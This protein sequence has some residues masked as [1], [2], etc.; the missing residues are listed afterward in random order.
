MAVSKDSP[1]APA[2]E[3]RYDRFGNPIDPT[4]SYARG[5][6]LRSNADEIRRQRQAYAIIR[7]RRYSVSAVPASILR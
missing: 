7:D 5:S 4:V 2:I 3:V 1:A 6:I